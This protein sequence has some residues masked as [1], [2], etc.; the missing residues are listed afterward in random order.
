MSVG[1]YVSA[2]G[3]LTNMHRLDV[4]SNNLANV[5]TTAFKRDFAY[6]IPRLPERLEDSLH[7]LG[8][9]ELLDQLA[10]GVLNGQTRTDFSP[11]PISV[12]NN[13]L[14]AAIDGEGFFVVDAGEGANKPWLTRDGRFTISA[15]GTLVSATSGMALL[16]DGDSPITVDPNLPVMLSPLGEIIQ[17]DRVVGR[18][19]L[20]TIPDTTILKK[21][22]GG[23]YASKFDAPLNLT[24]NPDIRIRPESIEDSGIDPI[25]ALMGVTSAGAGVRNNLR[26]MQLFDELDNRA[27]NRLGNVTG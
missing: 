25:K 10:G 2:S 3:A 4:A 5:N 24:R 23:F 19:K 11:G 21:T 13:P 27:I 7:H 17:G 18:L 15:N 6:Q 12:T 9:D 14:D 20:V 8:S 1:M 26:L 22:L 16:G